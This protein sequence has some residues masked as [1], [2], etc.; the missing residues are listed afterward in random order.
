MF[1]KS[2][3]AIQKCKRTVGVLIKREVTKREKIKSH[4]ALEVNLVCIKTNE[5]ERNVKKVGYFLQNLIM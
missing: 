4:N 2:N 1:G 5:N 3:P